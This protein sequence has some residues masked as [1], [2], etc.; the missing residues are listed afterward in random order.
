MSRYDG[1]EMQRMPWLDELAMVAIDG[2]L[3]E[4]ERRWEGEEGEGERG[5]AM[6]MRLVLELQ[7]FDHPVVFQ[8]RCYE[9]RS[10][11]VLQLR[12]W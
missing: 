12:C 6:P 5:S 2:V 4:E 10:N 11:V 8:V 1:G 7:T 9:A 3:E